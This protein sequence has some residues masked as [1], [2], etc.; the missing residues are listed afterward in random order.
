MAD[1]QPPSEE[2]PTIYGRSNRKLISGADTFANDL[3]GARPV[4]KLCKTESKTMRLMSVLGGY[5]VLP[6]RAATR[7]LARVRSF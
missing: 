5:T 3:Y 2:I 7:R 1:K 4:K 6:V